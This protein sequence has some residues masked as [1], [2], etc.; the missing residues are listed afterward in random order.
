[1]DKGR[2]EF[3]KN[4]AKFGGAGLAAVGLLGLHK[5]REFHGGSVGSPIP[6]DKLR[7]VTDKEWLRIIKSDWSVR[8]R[9]W[10]QMGPNH[11]GEAS[12]EHFADALGYIAE[13]QPQRFAALALH[14]PKNAYPGYLCRVLRAIALTKPPDSLKGAEKDT[15]QPATGEQIEEIL[16]YMGYFEVEL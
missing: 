1:M 12:H 3:F 11:V 14:I 7:F 13:Q 15:W 8:G 2:R 5:A 6:T 10:K 9:R 16:D 4:V